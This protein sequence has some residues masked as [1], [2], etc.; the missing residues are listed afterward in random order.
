[1]AKKPSVKGSLVAETIE[2]ARKTLEKGTLS[3][4]DLEARLRPEDLAEFREPP[5]LGRWYD[6]EF[7]QHLAEL[8]CEVEGGDR[9][10]Y[11]RKLG[12]ARG[13]MLN[14]RTRDQAEQRLPPASPASARAKDSSKG[15]RRLAQASA[16]CS[17]VGEA[18]SE[19]TAMEGSL[20]DQARDL[21][22][23]LVS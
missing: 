2:N 16:P 18:G 23:V 3:P 19:K 6:L 14:L 8:L 12:F 4:A 5:S 10:Q 11:F 7:Y 13:Q 21:T 15:Q 17:E 20:N 9:E 1:M 22:G